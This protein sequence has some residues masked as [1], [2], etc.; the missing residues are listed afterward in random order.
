M[1]VQELLGKFGYEFLLSLLG[2]KVY[3]L[4]DGEVVLEGVLTGITY[5]RGNYY[6]QLNYASVTKAIFLS[7]DDVN[8]AKLC[9]CSGTL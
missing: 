8:K 5:N 4:R 3:E 9:N 1:S 6:F 7:R 2:G